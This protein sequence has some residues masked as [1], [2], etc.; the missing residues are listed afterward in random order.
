VRDIA[1]SHVLTLHWVMRPATADDPVDGPI[2][3]SDAVIRT[4]LHAAA[5]TEKPIRVI[6]DGQLL[7]V[8]DRA[9]ILESIAGANPG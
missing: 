1:K 4:A 6:D 3:R 8:V 9:A 5:S 7:G 2:F